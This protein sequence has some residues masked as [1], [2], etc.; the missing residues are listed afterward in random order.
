VY[1]FPPGISAYMNLCNMAWYCAEPVLSDTC[2]KKRTDNKSKWHFIY[3]I[4]ASWYKWNK[5]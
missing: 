3:C 2:T 1:N 4:Y 5:M